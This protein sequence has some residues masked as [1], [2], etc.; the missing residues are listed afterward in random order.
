MLGASEDNILEITH[1]LARP[2]G[3][4]GGPIDITLIKPTTKIYV[5]NLAS[6]KTQGINYEIIVNCSIE[7]LATKGRTCQVIEF[8]VP[9][10]KKGAKVL[11]TELG[12]VVSLLDKKVDKGVLFVC[13]S[14]N[15][16]APAVALVIL[17]LYYD[18]EGKEDCFKHGL[19]GASR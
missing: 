2:L 11:R 10:G 16:I 17:C 19:L 3:T 8:P 5:G 12:R 7:P 1:S 14:G 4:S 15:D 13:S 18:G 9:D 6:A